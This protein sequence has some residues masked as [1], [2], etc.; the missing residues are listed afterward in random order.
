MIILI[1]GVAGTGKTSLA[2]KLCEEYEID[3]RLGTGF[4]REIVK[5]E[6]GLKTLDCHT[7]LISTM[8]PYNH[9]AKQTDLMKE[10]INA[11]IDR[12]DREGTDLVI[13]G[14]H[15]LPWVI[16]NPKVT[17][18]VILYIDNENVHKSMVRGKTHSKREIT[19]EEFGRIREMQESILY[20]AETNGTPYIEVSG[21]L[22]ETLKNVKGI[23][24]D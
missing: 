1:G 18:S 19:E 21:G 22:F 7:Y 17:H 4:I 8:Q 23:I 15:C 10:S 13:E 12:A 5:C 14:N 6:K 2:R 16:D 20:L 9:L 24:N 11:C 3:H